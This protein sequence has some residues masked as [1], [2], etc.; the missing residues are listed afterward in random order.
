MEKEEFRLPENAYR[1]LNEGEEYKPILDPTKKYKEVTTWSVAMGILMAI[2]FSAAAAYSGLKIGQ[3]FEAAIP[4]SIIAVG[5]TMAARKSDPLSQNVIIQSIGASSGVVVAGAVFT[6]P[7]LYILQHKYPSIEI[8]FWPIFFSSLLGGFLGILFLIP[9]RKYFVKD[10]HGKLPFPEAKATTEILVTGANVSKQSSILLKGGIIAGIYDF[11]INSLKLFQEEFTSRMVGWGAAIADKTKVVFKMNAS[12][13]VFSF[14]Y[15]VGLKYALIIVMGSLLSWWVFIPIIGYIGGMQDLSAELIFLDYVRPIGIG[16]IA[17]AGIIGIINSLPILSKSFGLLFNKKK[18]S[19]TEVL[20]TDKDIPS[21]FW[22]SALILVI[23]GILLFFILSVNLNWWQ[24]VIVLVALLIISFLFTTVAA[25]AIAIVGTNPVSGMTMMTLILMSLV[26]VKV[27]LKG[28]TGMVVAMLVGGIVCTALSTAGGFV[29][30]LKIGYWIGSSPYKQETFKF[31][32]ILVSAAT[33]GIVIFVLNQAYGFVKTPEHP[34][35]LV[36]PQANAMA[37]II[38]PFMQEN[39]EIPWILYLVGAITAIIINFLG[40]PPLAFAL[41]MF[42]PQGLNTPL[43]VGGLI[44]HFAANKTKNKE[45]AKAREQRGTLLASG[46]IAGAALFGVIGAL[47]LFFGLDLTVPIF[48]ELVNG[49]WVWIDGN[50]WPE[51]LSLVAFVLIV[52]YFIW[53]IRRAK[54]EDN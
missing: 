40:I 38:E 1:E 32:G 35:P 42:I 6:I 53:E 51:V 8:N 34:N 17:M 18:V 14:G 22:L 5:A 33:V 48:K 16:A 21:R 47:L 24:A 49:K 27:G 41:G 3:V 4:I 39:A 2:I 54:I 50:V 19:E 25:N 36:A 12:A 11:M 26:L 7:A 20:R 28:T 13:L 44:N 31:L 52:T 43:L 9:F 10:M 29:T 15:L 46:F 23:F 37:S 45:L 30:D